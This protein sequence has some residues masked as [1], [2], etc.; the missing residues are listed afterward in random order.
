MKSRILLFLFAVPL[1]AQNAGKNK[2]DLVINDAW[3]RVAASGSNSALFFEV[4]NNSAKPDTLFNAESP[5]SEVVEV[6]ET[7]K[8][9]NDM[10]GMRKVKFVVI[11]PKSSVKFKP[12]DLHV[13]LIK[14][15]K[16]LK[17]GD[18]GEATLIFKNSGRV[19]V[20]AAVRDMQTMMNK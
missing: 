7:F 12:R 10:M 14:L 16:D 3:I 4:I 5:L 17:A 9:E 6:H 8:R 19:K 15:K 2:S 13:M 11:P 20:E 1:L 18:K